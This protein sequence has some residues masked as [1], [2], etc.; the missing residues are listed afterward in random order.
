[1]LHELILVCMSVSVVIT[2]L[3]PLHLESGSTTC[4]TDNFCKGSRTMGM[5]AS[6][7]AYRMCKP[8]SVKL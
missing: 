2:T 1:M 6:Q 4:V 3:P 8:Q 7:E 5:F